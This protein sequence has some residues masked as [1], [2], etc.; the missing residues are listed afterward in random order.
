MP[1]RR[2]DVA[3]WR[4]GMAAWRE[5]GKR[6]CFAISLNCDGVPWQVAWRCS[7]EKAARCEGAGRKLGRRDA[8]GGSWEEPGKGAAKEEGFRNKA[9]V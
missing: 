2:G 5:L 6:E 3:L 8:L 4:C 9:L 7:W 1:V